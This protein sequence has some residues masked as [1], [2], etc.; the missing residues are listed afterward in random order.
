MRVEREIVINAPRRDVWEWV[1]DPSRYP[2]FMAGVSRWEQRSEQ[3]AGVGARYLARFGVGSAPVGAL[4]ELVECDEPCDL[5]WTS[6]TGVEHRGRWR[7]R[8]AGPG[9]TRVR[10]RVAYQAP[11]G[12]LGV[13]ADR[14]AA[15]MVARVIGQ[16][17]AELRGVVE[18]KAPARRTPRP[19]PAEL[20]S[21]AVAVVRSGVL[22]PPPPARL[23]A[24]VDAVRRWG[25]NPAAAVAL[26]A[27]RYPDAAAVVDQAGTLTYRQL[28]G[29]TNALAHG[30]AGRGVGPGTVVGL[31][32]RNHR[33][34]VE[35]AVALFK[36][37]ADVVMLNTGF[38]TSEVADVCR[39][40]G[41][42]LLVHDEDFAEAADA[43][44]VDHIAVVGGD[45]DR[46]KGTLES[47]RVGGPETPPSAPPKPGRVV[48]LT[49][50]TTGRPKGAPRSQGG[51]EVA[52]AVGLFSRI[53]LRARDTT[54][55]APPMFHAWGFAHLLIGLS[56]SSTLVLRRRFDPA[57]VLDD[58]AA[59][60]ATVLVAVP[61]MLQ[62]LLAVAEEEEGS[63]HDTSSLRVVAVSGSSLSGR[64]A[65]GFMDVFGDVVYNLY[66]STEVAWATI[67][68]PRQLRAAPGTAGTPPPGTI[69]RIVDEQGIEQPRGRTGRIFVGNGMT[70]SGYTGGGGK[71]VLHGLVDTGDLGRFD[72]AGR[73]FVEG[74]ADD[75]I[76]SGG[77]NVFPREVEEVIVSHA[78][79]ADAAVIGVDDEEF[80]QRLAAFVVPRQGASI[81]PDEVRVHVR[82]RLA[83][84]KVPRDVELLEELPRNATGKVL[85]RQLGGGGDDGS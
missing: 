41:V 15:P 59:H 53:P 16:T 6:V 83:R 36:L 85:K 32:C 14:V 74:R 76:V 22:T 10:L 13:I 55:I 37:G 34:F 33:G 26:S 3:A 21:A 67:A 23:P 60:R 63:G 17:L 64:L 5:A 65:Q 70:F 27:A 80:G 43:A 8:D 56:L 45:G 48:I 49:S 40:E 42:T 29:R 73:L 84:Y 12:L 58:I 19:R 75:M 38:S 51:A 47:L 82:G 24:T 31:L 7:L 81:T 61:Q 11:G 4:I 35:A 9:Q 62:R 71:T 54:V 66:G 28:D 39:S 79:V 46:R 25:L 30:L 50:G 78:D 18:Q 1:A 72:V 2:T 57:A 20:V 69:V 77:E 44:G 52:P 68:D